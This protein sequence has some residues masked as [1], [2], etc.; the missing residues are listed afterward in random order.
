MACY[1]NNYDDIKNEPLINAQ[2]EE[3]KNLLLKFS[4]YYLDFIYL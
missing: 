4:E 1:I 2:F 3:L